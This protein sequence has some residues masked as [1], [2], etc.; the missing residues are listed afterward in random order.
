MQLHVNQ[1]TNENFSNVIDSRLC[2]NTAYL[3]PKVAVIQSSVAVARKTG[4]THF[5]EVLI[6]ANVSHYSSLY[7][8]IAPRELGEKQFH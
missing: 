6:K 1:K 3:C 2:N 5:T 7:L 8:P 4:V